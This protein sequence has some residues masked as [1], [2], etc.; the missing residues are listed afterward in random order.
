MPSQTRRTATAAPRPNATQARPLSGGTSGSNLLAQYESALM[1]G[2]GRGTGGNPLGDFAQG[3]NAF[4]N[5]SGNLR[6]YG[7]RLRGEARAHERGMQGDQLRSQE[8]QTGMQTGA[9]TA[10]ARMQA[11]A[12]RHSATTQ[13]GAQRDTANTQARAQR[14][15]AGIQAGAD[16]FSALKQLEGIRAQTAG[17]VQEAGIGAKAQVDVAGL[18]TAA[19]RYLGELDAGT[20]KYKAN[21]DLMGNLAGLASSERI[22]KGQQSGETDRTRMQLAGSIMMNKEDNATARNN[23]FFDY[24]GNVAQSQ[25]RTPDVNN[26]KYWG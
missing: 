7:D 21:T 22:A 25:W 26:I 13:A 1:N 4:W 2:V 6:D 15:V 14:D 18:Q 5:A 24:M 12:Q 9:Q 23:K 20:Q 3:A 8:A 16:N 11:D 19:Q 10:A 17:R